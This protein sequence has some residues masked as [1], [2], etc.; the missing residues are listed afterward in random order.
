MLTLTRENARLIEQTARDEPDPRLSAALRRLAQH[1][2]SED[3]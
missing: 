1:A 2:A 3:Q